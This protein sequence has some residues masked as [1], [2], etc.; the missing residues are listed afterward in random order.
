MRKVS[1]KYK[2]LAVFMLTA[3]IALLFGGCWFMNEPP[4]I[5]SF[6]LFS[7][8]E[9]NTGDI[10]QI[11]CI[12]LDAD[13]DELS[14]NWSADGG[15]FIGEGSTVQWKA[16]DEA[17]SYTISVEVSD[18]SDDT[19]TEEMTVWV[20]MPNHPPVIESFSAEWSR[21]KKAS[22]TPLTCLASDPD[23]DVLTYTWTATDDE[24]N[25]VGTFDGE[26][27]TVTWYAPNDYGVYTIICTVSDSR[28]GEAEAGAAITVCA[29]GS[30]H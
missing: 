12:A 2:W 8:D 25:P 21:L 24:G 14:Y 15:T 29:C 18:G 23:D 10:C 9:L 20:A 6:T 30:A 27:T 1:P 19:A 4:V 3:V 13:E 22:N 28:G 7:V 5:T 16:P 11:D 17:G 26:G